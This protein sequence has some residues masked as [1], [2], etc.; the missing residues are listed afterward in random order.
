M[1][2]T[3]RLATPADAAACVAIYSPHVRGSAVSFEV[4]APSDEEF[5]ARIRGALERY[6][7]LVC[8]E[9]G[10]VL[11]YAYA[12][13]HQQRAAFQWSVDVS[14]YVHGGHERRGV[15]RALYT[16]LFACLRLLG[17]YNAYAAIALPHAASA[18]L[19]EAMGFRRIG[20][21]A[22]VGHKLGEW[23]SV[24]WWGL[25]LRERSAPATPE[26]LADVV[27]T[28]AWAEAVAA[29]VRA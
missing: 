25:A 9:G 6:P 5:A 12:G 13:P 26:L 23:R 1:E 22:D 19:H 4:D 27:G 15:G 18:G 20:T 8:A 3:I 21:F 11:G 24:G 28:A 7:W 16:S 29:G 17:Y 10:V 14:V 2:R